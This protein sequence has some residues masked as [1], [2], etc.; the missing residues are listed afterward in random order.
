MEVIFLFSSEETVQQDIPVWMPYT[1]I[2]ELLPQIFTGR[3][4]LSST[5]GYLDILKF[6]MITSQIP[7]YWQF[8]TTS[9]FIWHNVCSY[10]SVVK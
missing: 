7:N 4:S 1:C 5:G 8:I 3:I 9:H 6:V 10:D 2:Q